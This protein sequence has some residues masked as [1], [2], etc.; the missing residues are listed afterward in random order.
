MLCRARVI[1][2]LTT[3]EDCLV[4]GAYEALA[5][6]RPLV[7]SDARALRELLKDG[8]MYA[9]NEPASIA[10]TINEAAAN[11]ALLASRCAERREAY[12]IEWRA[13]ASNLL[14]Q[15]EQLA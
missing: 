14:S 13:A 2:D 7:V 9:D 11:E 5:V 15:V 3:R 8:A 1:V 4:C 6:G 12:V 10:R